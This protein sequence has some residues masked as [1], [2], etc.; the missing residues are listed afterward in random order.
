MK[1]NVLFGAA[2]A[3]LFAFGACTKDAPAPDNGGTTSGGGTTPQPQQKHNVE[4]VYGRVPATTWQHIEMDTL[5]KYSED[6]TVDTIFMIPEMTN[7]FSTNSTNGLKNL[8]NLLR[9]RHNVNPDK[10][11]GKGELQLDADAVRDNIEIVRFFADTLKY[12]V[13]YYNHAKSR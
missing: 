9:E 1:K 8:I 3:L 13:T 7:Q 5:Y 10:V 6:K 4:L 11:F 2:V 12:K